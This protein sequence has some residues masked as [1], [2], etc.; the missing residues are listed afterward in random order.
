M[1]IENKY[2]AD[3]APDGPAD[4]Q[5]LVV[6]SDIDDLPG[7]TRGVYVGITGNVHIGDRFGNEVVWK[8]VQAG[9]IIPIRAHKILSSG[10][11]ADNIVG[12]V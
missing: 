3:S 8:N 7:L 4:R 5:F 2:K 1:A 10:T 11:T 12:L 9:S 6:P